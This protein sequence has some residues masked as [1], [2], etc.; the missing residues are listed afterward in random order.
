[1]TSHYLLHKKVFDTNSYVLFEKYILRDVEFSRKEKMRL[2]HS[3]SPD[4]VKVYSK[5]MKRYVKF[6]RRSDFEPY[7]VTEVSIRKF[8]DSLDIEKDR[9]QVP[10]IKS[11][12][13]FA[14]KIRGDPAI[15]FTSTDFI[16]EG[17]LREI[18]ANFPKKFKANE[19]K[20][21]DVRK[22][23]LYCLYGKSFCKPYNTKL[24]EFRTGV[25][26]LVSL[27]CL[28]R[29][30]D[31]MKL[32][33]EDIT[34]E[35]DHAVIVWRERKN[36]QKGKAQISILPRIKNHPLCPVKS[37]KYWLNITKMTD[38]QFVNCKLSSGGKAVGKLGISR[39]TCYKDM[40]LVS[41]QLKLPMITE[42][43]CKSLGT[44]YNYS[45]KNVNSIYI[46][47]CS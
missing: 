44:R 4:T 27:F 25:R 45:F 34:I 33:K 1:M 10:N 47:D 19:V 20:E 32:K 21:L 31:Y 30:G 18:G 46:L 17:L 8:I 16:I 38:K 3:R 23:L 39:S 28:S 40:R 5:V 41:D 13:T 29:G 7:P 42:K 2:F 15:S 11:A 9:G 36:N 35:K 12:F 43:I 14:Q 22:F 26:C 37:M 24:S 6:A